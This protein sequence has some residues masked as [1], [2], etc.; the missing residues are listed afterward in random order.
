MQQQAEISGVEAQ[1]SQVVPSPRVLLVEADESARSVLS[2][3]LKA[4]GLSVLEADTGAMALKLLRDEAPELAIVSTQLNGED[5]LSVVAQMRGEHPDRILQVVLLAKDGESG[6]EQLSKVVDADEVLLKPAFAKE[7]AAVAVMQLSERTLDGTV[8]LDA[9]QAPPNQLLRALLNGDRSGVFEL[10]GGRAHIAFRKGLV[11][12]AQVD[13][14]HGPDALV[15]ALAIHAGPYRVAFRPVQFQPAFELG[16]KDVLQKIEPRL[17]QFTELAEQSVGL[18]SRLEIEFQS[19]A[20]ALPSLPDAANAVVR[21]F[22]GLRTVR[23]VVLDSPQDELLTLQVTQ[24]L[25]AL[26]VIKVAEEHVRP[27]GGVVLFGNRRDDADQQMSELFSAPIQLAT[28]A[29]EDK[30]AADSTDWADVLIK[31][32]PETGDPSAGWVAGKLEPEL[33]KQLEAFDIKAIDEAPRAKAEVLSPAVQE[34]KDFAAPIPLT[35]AVK[36]VEPAPPEVTPIEA[37]SIDALEDG[38]FDH[39]SRANPI[40]EP[41]KTPPRPKAGSTGISA[42][43]LKAVGTTTSQTLNAVSP[44]PKRPGTMTIAALLLVVAV[45]VV[46]AMFAQRESGDTKPI[47]P[48]QVAPAPAP[49]PE[50]A[51]VEV[52]N[53][54]KPATQ[55]MIDA[56]AKL[57]EDG[58]LEGA[59][60]A[61]EQ[62]VDDD[63]S[64]VPALLLMSEVKLDWGDLSG[65]GEAANNVLALDAKNARAH[66]LLATIHITQWRK[67]TD[68]ESK[69]RFRKAADGEIQ[70]AL[71]AD[72]NGKFADEARALLKR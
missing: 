7:V 53:V 50:P 68:P 17:R 2:V 65:A 39:P 38:F 27:S 48:V 12:D 45:A 23:Q 26:G 30:A 16:V 40:P 28:A 59:L 4:S 15:K 61:L 37:A 42:A 66:L 36:P 55:E 19:L 62:I 5:G 63:P 10:C 32:E 49:A 13:R 67:E 21:L 11:I 35:E 52:V 20:K 31:G 47:A 46:A 72:P 56:A 24:R 25:L 57:Y 43:A 58:K 8:K 29:S 22:D 44:E 6:L 34:L 33:A 9:T 18:E 71:D 69:A 54:D 60:K 41:A 14:Q 64:S 51:P 1:L 70:Q 3:T